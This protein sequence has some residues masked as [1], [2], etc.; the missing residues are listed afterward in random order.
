MSDTRTP[1]R[2]GDEQDDL[3][4]PQP[5]EMSEEEINTLDSV[6]SSDILTPTTSWF[7][8]VNNLTSTVYSTADAAYMPDTDSRYTDW[9]S[10]GNIATPILSDGELADVLTKM[11]ST[12]PVVLNTN[13][14]D[15]GLCG[16][17]DIIAAMQ[18]AGVVLTST[19]NAAISAHYQ[20]SGP[21]DTMMRTQIYINAHNQ[22]PN[23]QPLDWPAYD[24]TVTFATA[25]DFTAAYGGLQD[26]FNAWQTWALSD[27]TGPAPTW[28]AATIA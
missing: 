21:F 28:G 17:A 9:T 3:P 23:N 19:G 25:A 8:I 10:L 20:L 4:D 2:R 24:K 15:W 27:R 5:L 11:G 13:P 7:W 1:L 22:L 16:S 12:G 14:T 6:Q 26:Y 18:A